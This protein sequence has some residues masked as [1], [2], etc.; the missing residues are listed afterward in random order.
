MH[1]SSKRGLQVWTMGLWA[2]PSIEVNWVVGPNNA[3]SLNETLWNSRLEC[4]SGTAPSKTMG[5][6]G[7]GAQTILGTRDWLRWWTQ[8]RSAAAG[9]CKAERRRKEP[10]LEQGLMRGTAKWWRLRSQEYLAV[11]RRG[12]GPCAV[13]SLAIWCKGLRVW[14]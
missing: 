11:E 1:G 4:K 10:K 5:Q 14:E 2:K 7:G 13:V 8:C 9:N 12:G 3:V 6:K